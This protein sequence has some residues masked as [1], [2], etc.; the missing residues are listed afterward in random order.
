MNVE[1]AMD[2]VPVSFGNNG[3]VELLQN[4]KIFLEDNS[5][6]VKIS[7]DNEKRIAAL[8]TDWADGF[9]LDK[10]Q[11]SYDNLLD[12]FRLALWKYKFRK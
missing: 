7:R 4:A 9:K 1:N 12:A 3:G 11:T 2:V 8:R 5:K 10:D 6:L